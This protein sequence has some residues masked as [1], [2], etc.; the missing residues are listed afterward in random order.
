VSR[1]PHIGDSDIRKQRRESLSTLHLAKSQND[2]RCPFVGGH[3]E[4]IGESTGISDTGDLNRQKKCHRGH[5][6]SK[7]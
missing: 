3:V 4:E 7:I 5:R 6:V 2:M 1:D